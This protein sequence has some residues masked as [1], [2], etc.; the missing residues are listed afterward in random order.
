MTCYVQSALM[1]LSLRIL[2]C[3]SARVP[4]ATS[5]SCTGFYVSY[6]RLTAWSR[7]MHQ[8]PHV[9]G[10]LLSVSAG[11]TRRCCITL[12]SRPA[13]SPVRQTAMGKDTVL[14][15]SCMLDTPCTC[16]HTCEMPRHIHT[17]IPQHN[18]SAHIR[19]NERV[20]WLS[21]YAVFVC[22][23]HSVCLGLLC[24]HA[25]SGQT[26]LVTV[27]WLS[28]RSYWIQLGLYPPHNRHSRNSDCR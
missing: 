16:A 19:L 27:G 28:W 9:L 18:D 22:V 8:P 1:G 25:G 13:T 21:L 11:Q 4:S 15:A 10:R 24:I 3:Q 7:S 12:G 14:Q 26:S 6:V 5:R 17:C 2:A 20:I 23:R